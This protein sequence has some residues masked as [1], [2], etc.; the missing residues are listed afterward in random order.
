MLKIFKEIAI[1][2]SKTKASATMFG[3]FEPNLTEKIKTEISKPS[4]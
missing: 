4:K 2:N 1:K 3:W